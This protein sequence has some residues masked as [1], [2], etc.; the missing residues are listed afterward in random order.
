MIASVR[1]SPRFIK[2]ANEEA[3]QKKILQLQFATGKEF[4]FL[5]IYPVR[6]GVVAWYYDRTDSLE[7]LTTA[8][9]MK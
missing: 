9:R 2:A 6:G 4:A 5:T 8:L 7:E 1:R 3:L